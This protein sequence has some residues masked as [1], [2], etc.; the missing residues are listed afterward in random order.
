MVTTG[1]WAT[2]T[3]VQ[4]HS[5]FPDLLLVTFSLDRTPSEANRY[6]LLRIT[7]AVW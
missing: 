5:S 4:V 6:T 2:V 7:V 3:C 1:T